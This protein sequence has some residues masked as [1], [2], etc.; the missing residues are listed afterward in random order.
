M[1]VTQVSLTAPATG[2]AVLKLTSTDYLKVTQLGV[3]ARDLLNGAWADWPGSVSGVNIG[4]EGYTYISDAPNTNLVAGHTYSVFGY[5]RT[6]DLVWHN[7]PAGTLFVPGST[8]APTPDIPG[9]TLV[10]DGS[11]FNDATKWNVGKTSSFPNTGPTNPGDNKQDWISPSNAPANGVFSADRRSDGKWNT[12]LVTTEYG[13][14]FQLQPGDTVLS[15]FTLNA[16]QGVWV[17]SWTWGDGSQPGH[18]EIDFFEYHGDNPRLLEISNHVR[19]T[20]SGIYANNAITPGVPFT[21]RTDITTTSVNTY[22]DGVLVA[23]DGKGVPSTWRAW[24]I[25]EISVSAGQYH[26]APSSSQTHMEFTCS[27]Y[28]VYR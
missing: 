26:P 9:K 3:A 16:T 19:S 10:W 15:R 11:N 28:R 1:T 20:S 21:L 5:Y 18:G 27:S 25:V 4:P 6:A 23:Q 24:P 14:H 8:P 2:R 7:F 13:S 22:V 12:D 17:S